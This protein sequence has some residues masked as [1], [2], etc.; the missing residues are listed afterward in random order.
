M[1]ILFIS[2][3]DFETI[4]TSGIYTDLLREFKKNGDKVYAISPTE[5]KK[6]KHDYVIEEDG[7]VIVKPRIGNIQKTTNIEKALSML[8][9]EPILNRA[10]KKYLSDVKIDLVLYPTPPITFAN[11]IAYIKKR[12]GAYAYLMLKDIFPAGAV[13]LGALKKTGLKGVI[14]RYFR[15]KEKY[16]YRISDKI[17]CMSRGNVEYLKANNK[18]ENS[19]LE[20]CPNAVEPTDKRL[21]QQ[22][23]TAVRGEFGLPTNKCIFIYGGNLG[24]PQGIPFVIECLKKQSVNDEAFYVIIG[25]GTE[26][27]LL[28][29]FIDQDKPQN[30]KLIK[31]LPKEKYD[32]LMSACDV[33]LIFLEHNFTIPNI[34]SRILAYMQAGLPV[35]AATDPYT[36]L[37]NIIEQGEFGCWCESNDVNTFSNLVSFLVKNESIRHRYGNNA[38]KTLVQDYNVVAVYKTIKTSIDS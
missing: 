22:E 32:R 29:S 11:T 1:N 33:G 25:D 6:R 15:K 7:V 2:L 5:R 38:Q 16:L 31:R 18:L 28:Q 24:K 12:D 14:Y 34:P 3:I 36:D 30:V 9:I 17:G 27:G 20:E 4:K 23:K 10:I 37:H 8:T 21:S 19:K 35:L 26:F 13:D